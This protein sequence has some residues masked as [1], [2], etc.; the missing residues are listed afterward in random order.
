MLRIGGPI[1]I[2]LLGVG[3][4]A[5]S[6]IESSRIPLLRNYYL[7]IAKTCLLIIGDRSVS[8]E[9][10]G[11][12]VRLLSFILNLE[13]VFEKYV[14]NVLKQW[15]KTEHSEAKVRDGNKGKRNYLFYDSRVFDIYPDIYLTLGAKRPLV[16]DVKYKPK[17]EE[18]DRYQVISHSVSMGATKAVIIVPA[19]QGGN[20]GL[21][22]RG[23]IC[24]ANGIEVFEYHMKLDGDLGSEEAK[25]GKA[26]IEL[27]SS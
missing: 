8:L 14:R 16:A 24:D 17:I 22:R 12:D 23:Q 9:T 7:G 20:S 11:S 13:D 18:H 15:V 4:E 6:T 21:I 25:M 19:F 5:R 10:A 2:E 26:I 3:E 27:G 1:T